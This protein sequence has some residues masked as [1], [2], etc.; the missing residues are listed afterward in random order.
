MRES[1]LPQFLTHLSSTRK[2]SNAREKALLILSNEKY[3]TK[4]RNTPQ[5]AHGLSLTIPRSAPCFHPLGVRVF[6]HFSTLQYPTALTFRLL[7]SRLLRRHIH[8]SGT[9]RVKRTSFDSEPLPYEWPHATNNR[10]TT[11]Y[12]PYRRLNVLPGHSPVL[13]SWYTYLPPTKFK[14]NRLYAH[15]GHYRSSCPPIYV[16]RSL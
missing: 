13:D 1:Y 16:S 2:F 9:G 11:P 14:W 7:R 15:L 5:L 8:Q 10:L 12:A 4:I 3:N 6:S